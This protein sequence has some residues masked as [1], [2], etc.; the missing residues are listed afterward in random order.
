[1]RRI[2]KPAT[3]STASPSLAGVGCQRVARQH[4]QAEAGAH[5]V[6]QRLVAAQRHARRPGHAALG[7]QVLQRQPC[8]RAGLARQQRFTDQL[9]QRQPLARGKRMA[10][11]GDRNQRVVEKGPAVQRQL[12]WRQH[13]RRE[14]DAAGFELRDDGV[15]VLDRQLD[16]DAGIG[17][18]KRAQQVGQEVLGGGDG[19]QPQPAA[20]QALQRSRI[21]FEA[22]PGRE[23]L[24]RRGGQAFADSGRHQ[25]TPLRLQQRQPD[26]GSQFLQLRA[27]RGLGQA[28]RLR[29][30]AHGTQAHDSFEAA[31]LHQRH[32]RRAVQPGGRV[33]CH[34]GFRS[35]AS[36]NIILMDAEP[37]A[38]LA[39]MSNFLDP[40][41]LFFVFGLLAGALRSNLEIP[42]AISRFLSLYLLM[43]LGL[44]GGFALAKSGLTAEVTCGSGMRPGARGRR[45]VAIGYA[46]WWLRRLLNGFDAA[47]HC[48]N[49]RLGQ[50]GDVHHRGAV[51][52]DSK[53]LPTSVVTWRRRWR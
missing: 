26:C 24:A 4:G 28:Q 6:F 25:A 39:A 31:Q 17:A 16:A 34:R 2:G 49:L 5:R 10:G 19:R 44:K 30:A 50:R 9:R 14:L 37:T 45:A 8:A 38:A 33:G 7:E 22:L 52:G 13:H 32:T 27:D 36:E 47:A 53:A 48:R 29:G 12:R 51:S 40:A 46:L 21:V 15:A 20:L 3:G 42:P 18:R 43:A 41:I 1:M 35:N 23:H 11:R